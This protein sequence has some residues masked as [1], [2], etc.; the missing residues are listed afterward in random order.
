MVDD[1]EGWKE[2]TKG[3]KK[4]TKD[5]SSEKSSISSEEKAVITDKTEPIR[6]VIHSKVHEYTKISLASSGVMTGKQAEKMDK[7][8]L[9]IDAKLDLHGYTLNDAQEKL[10]EFIL[11]SYHQNKRLVL[12][13]TGKGINSSSLSTIKGEFM[14]WLNIPKLRPYILRVSQAKQKDGGSGAYYVY[15]KRCKA[16]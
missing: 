8:L 4:I 13:I 16:C 6:K 5:E 1:L 10:C 3:V 7:G 15:L 14:H 11:N 9:K 2:F 12:I